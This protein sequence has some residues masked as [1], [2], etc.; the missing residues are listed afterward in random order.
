MIYKSSKSLYIMKIDII[1]INNYDT[2]FKVIKI[3][4]KKIF[5]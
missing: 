3:Y 2:C 4:I 5:F 1:F